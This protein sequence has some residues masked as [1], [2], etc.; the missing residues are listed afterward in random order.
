MMPLSLCGL[1]MM[2]V[3]SLCGLR[4]R[5]FIFSAVVLLAPHSPPEIFAETH[6]MSAYMMDGEGQGR[7]HA[8]THAH[9]HAHTHTHNTN[10]FTHIHPRRT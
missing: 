2:M 10:V 9:A 4:Y 6:A 8:R 5:C 1:L 3:L 7:M